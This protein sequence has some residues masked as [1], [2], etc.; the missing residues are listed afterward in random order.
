MTQIIE[1][2][3][4]F[5]TS[6]GDLPTELQDALTQ[7][8]DQYRDPDAKLFAPAWSPDLQADLQRLSRQ[9]RIAILTIIQDEASGISLLRR[10]KTPYS[11]PTCGWFSQPQLGN[12]D[13]RKAALGK[14]I[15]E[16][17]NR[18]RFEQDDKDG[19]K[20]IAGGHWYFIA[21]LSTYY[22]KWTK[23]KD[24]TGCLTRARI[25]FTENALSDAALILKRAAPGAAQELARQIDSAEKDGDR[26]LASVAILDR[27]DLTT[28]PKAD[29]P[30]RELL[31]ELRDDEEPE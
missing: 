16:C 6:L 1:Q 7:T 15:I 17:E 13:E 22:S 25:E 27:A 28:A 26:R 30:Y 20:V 11:C 19:Q 18:L 21:N 12:R 5:I 8:I 10:L 4:N 2:T 24:F 14:H 3:R 23:D 9:K 29:D 31:R